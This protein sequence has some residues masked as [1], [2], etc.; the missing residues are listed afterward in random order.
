MDLILL[1]YTD[2]Y[3]VKRSWAMLGSNPTRDSQVRA[4]ATTA[5]PVMITWQG[6]FNTLLLSSYALKTHSIYPWIPR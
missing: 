2:E 5:D 4:E 1:R 3:L 6:I